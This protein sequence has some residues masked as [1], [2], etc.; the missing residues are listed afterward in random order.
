VRIVLVTGIA[1]VDGVLEAFSIFIEV[2]AVRLL[3]AG[4]LRPDPGAHAWHDTRPAVLSI[5]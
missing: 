3:P 1:A 5:R 4:R 2:G